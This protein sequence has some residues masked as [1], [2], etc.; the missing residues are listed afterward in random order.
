M[1]VSGWFDGLRPE[2]L[3]VGARTCLDEGR[4]ILVEAWGLR[5]AGPEDR[6][7]IDRLELGERAI[8]DARHENDGDSMEREDWIVVKAMDASPGRPFMEVLA[9]AG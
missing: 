9:A 3:E 8:L 4:G 5:D 6:D 2:D 7:L 1:Q